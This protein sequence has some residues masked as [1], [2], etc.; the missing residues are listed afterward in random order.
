MSNLFWP[1]ILLLLAIALTVLEA[2]IPSAG[3]LSVAAALAF[4]GAIVTAFMYGGLK[5]GTFFLITTGILLPLLIWLLIR[6]WPKTPIGRRILIQPPREDEILSPRYAAKKQLIGRHGIALTA[7]LPA[8]AIRIEG[9][10]I[11]A[12]SEGMTIEKNTPIEV[13]AVR[14]NHLVVRPLAASTDKPPAASMDAVIPDPFDD[15]LS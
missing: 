13:I 11:D 15:S 14:G 6:L 9:R 12:I 2:F 4:I 5:A 8:G 10:T 7:M 3:I 1:I